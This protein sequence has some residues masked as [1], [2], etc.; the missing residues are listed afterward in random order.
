[1]HVQF[2]TIPDTREAFGEWG[3]EHSRLLV[4]PFNGWTMLTSQGSPSLPTFLSAP[5][6][7]KIQPRLHDLGLILCLWIHQILLVLFLCY[8]CFFFVL[9]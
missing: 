3:Y 6:S 5:L 8:A 9:F 4:P 2:A 7:L 1:M